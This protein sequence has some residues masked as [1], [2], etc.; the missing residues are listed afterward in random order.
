M[1]SACWNFEVAAT[2]KSLLLE[3]VWDNSLA[4]PDAQCHIHNLEVHSFAKSSCGL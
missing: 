2:T 3:Q 1:A 4:A